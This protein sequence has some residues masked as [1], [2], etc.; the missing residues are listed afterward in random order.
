MLEEI[1]P[2]IGFFLDPNRFRGK[3]VV[4]PGVGAYGHEQGEKRRQLFHS[5]RQST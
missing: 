1:A 2:A 5:R 3:L 4:N